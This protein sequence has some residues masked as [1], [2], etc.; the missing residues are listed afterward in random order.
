MNKCKVQRTLSG[1]QF[2]FSKSFG[3][4][5]LSQRPCGHVATPALLSPTAA[6]YSGNPELPFPS[7]HRWLSACRQPVSMGTESDKG[8][9]VLKDTMH[10]WRTSNLG[11]QGFCHL[12][13]R[14]YQKPLTLQPALLLF[15]IGVATW[16]T[17]N[18]DHHW[19]TGY[20]HHPFPC[21]TMPLLVGHA[22]LEFPSVQK[23]HGHTFLKTSLSS[24]NVW[25]HCIEKGFL[26]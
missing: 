5:T 22:Q 1:I 11:T 9:S 19:V 8:D 12:K 17:P 16:N 23:L 15:S 21:I 10:P 3:I 26:G 20:C 18:T 13:E 4:C 24:Q 14:S 6:G 2:T 25:S 7:L